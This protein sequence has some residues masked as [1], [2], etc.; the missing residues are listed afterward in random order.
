MVETLTEPLKGDAVYL[1]TDGYNRSSSLIQETPLTRAAYDE[2]TK[3]YTYMDYNLSPDILRDLM[4]NIS[5]SIFNDGQHLTSTSVT[6][7]TYRL[8]YVFKSPWRLIAVY[9]ADLI[10]TAIFLLL[11]LIA[12]FQNGV[13]A[14]PGGFLQILCTTT[15]EHGTL[16]RLARQACSGGKEGMS[17]H[18]KKL[19]VRFGEIVDVNEDLRFAAFGTEE[20][21]SLLVNKRAH[22]GM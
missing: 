6:T 16:N 19:K 21:T 14:T 8:S 9:A 5:L 1:G 22:G 15:H 7:E 3:D 18:L 10:V 17:E 4:T 12:M 20:E 2:Q 13:A 11:G